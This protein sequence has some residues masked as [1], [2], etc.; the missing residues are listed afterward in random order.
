M[1][2]F[3]MERF[4]TGQLRALQSP[5][6]P[7]TLLPRVLAAA[8]AWADRPWYA[9]EWFT[10]PL[11]WQLASVALILGMIASGIALT[12]IAQ[13]VVSEAG[14]SLTPRIAIDVT[15][16][17]GGLQVSINTLRVIWRGL[18]EPFLPYA[19]V[20]VLLMCGACLSVVFALNRLVFGRVLH[21]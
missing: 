7:L 18:V 10:W 9:R 16:V 15:P 6:A 2:A 5:A 4:V 19:L 1:N 13:Q 14:A 8:K 3:E 11:G 20:I 17:A 12:P 21:S